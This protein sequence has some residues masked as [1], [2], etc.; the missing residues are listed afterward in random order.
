MESFGIMTMFELVIAVYLLY[1]AI[2]GEGKL[3]ENDYLKC[4]REEYV[5]GMRRF[6]VVTGGLM[7]ISSGLELLKV[8]DPMS[9]IGIILWALTFGCIIAMMIYSVK[10]T[11]REAA[12]AGKATACS[13]P[14]KPHDPLRAAFVFD[15][16]EE[17]AEKAQE[18]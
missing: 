14:E 2:K 3:Y 8:V 7:L 13:Q 17:E 9:P 6:A 10:K 16:E 1:C 4:S 18:E 12:N 11:D 15:D 5:K